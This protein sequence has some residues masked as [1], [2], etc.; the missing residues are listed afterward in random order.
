[1]LLYIGNKLSAYG[2]TPTSVETLGP[3]LQEKY[4]TLLISDKQSKIFRLFH[5]ILTLIK[6]RKETE[7]V[8]MDTYSTINLLYVFIGA[9]LCILFKIPYIPILRGGNLPE[10]VRK[11]PKITQFIFGNAYVNIAPSM[12]LY[13]P[14][15]KAGFKT[16]YIPNNIDLTI[17]DFKER[18][19][20]SKNILYVRALQSIYNPALAIEAF[21]KVKAKYPEATLCMIGPDKDNSLPGLKVLVSKLKIDDAISFKGMVPKPEWIKQAADYDLFINS[22]NF[23]NHPVSVIEAM[24]LGLP[25]VTTNVGGIPHLVTNE[26]NGL[27]VPPKDVD[28]FYNAIERLLKDEKLANKLSKGG[29][30][31]AESFAWQTVKLQWFELIDGIIAEKRAKKA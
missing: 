19:K 31:T 24:A 15:Q 10:R 23:D 25:V 6:R 21:A 30:K 18:S 20:L 8:L 2:A 9:C 1:M 7:V 26:E 4:Q 17:Y 5:I 13:E 27:M 22:T 29:R 16:Q 12:Y 11:L 28:Q 3:K 14:F